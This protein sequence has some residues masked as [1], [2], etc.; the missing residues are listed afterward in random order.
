VAA[1]DIA[2]NRTVLDDELCVELY[3]NVDG[4]TGSPA[5]GSCACV[6]AARA[7]STAGWAALFGV[8]LL[9]ARRRRP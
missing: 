5:P 6:I 8:A 9:L 3:A 7:P 1:I 2:G 4:V